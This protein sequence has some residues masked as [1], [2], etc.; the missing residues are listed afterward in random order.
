ML[1]KIKNKITMNEFAK[2]ISYL[3]HSRTQAHIFHLQ[4]DSFAA[5]SALNGYYDAI[6]GLTDGLVE[7]YQGKYGILTNYSNFSILE[8]KSCEEVIMYFQGLDMT[9]EKLR[10]S[11][12][13]D[14][15]IQN[16]VDTIV[17]LVSSTIYK[18]KFLK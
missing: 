12:P 15:Y 5:H 17:E 7:S 18:L 16:Q 9:I 6:I 3:F 1:K 14:S 11:I 2:L 8:Y 13:Q 10:K 4:T